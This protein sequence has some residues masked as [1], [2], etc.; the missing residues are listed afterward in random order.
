M[1]RNLGSEGGREGDG[2][3]DGFPERSNGRQS[4]AERD[5][6]RQIQKLT[7]YR[8]PPKGRGRSQVW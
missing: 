6:L 8:E 1:E 3:V 5:G 4:E 7:L 2:G